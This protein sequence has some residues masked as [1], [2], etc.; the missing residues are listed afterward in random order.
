MTM[1]ING[2]YFC[3]ALYFY[4]YGK[5]TVKSSQDVKKKHAGVREDIKR[6]EV[7]GCKAVT[8]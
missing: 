2:L 3:S 6:D 8:A 5:I 4:I 7:Q 1:Q